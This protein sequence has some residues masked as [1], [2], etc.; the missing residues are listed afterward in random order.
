[1]NPLNDIPVLLRGHLPMSLTLMDS[2]IVILE[3]VATQQSET[4]DRLQLA[5]PMTDLLSYY[6]SRLLAYAIT[7]PEGLLLTLKIPLASRQTVLTLFEA[8]LIPIPYPNDP[9]AV[10]I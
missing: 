3:N 5:I 6:E 10:P 2:L 9:Q 7:V 8:K 4:A 1:M